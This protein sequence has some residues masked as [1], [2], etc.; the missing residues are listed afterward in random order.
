M[1]PGYMPAQLEKR[2][3]VKKEIKKAA[4]YAEKADVSVSLTD[5]VNA[6]KLL[7]EEL[8][9]VHKE[10]EQFKNRMTR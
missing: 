6:L 10:L 8:T 7:H 2:M 9:A 4:D 3:S 5:V 1:E